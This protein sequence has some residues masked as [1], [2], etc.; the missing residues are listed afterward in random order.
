MSRVALIGENSIENIRALLDI[1]NSG[2]YA[3]LIAKSC[4]IQQ[5]K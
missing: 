4:L 1:W 3:V 2:G 5:L